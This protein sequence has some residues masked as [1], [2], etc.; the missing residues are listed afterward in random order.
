VAF[1]AGNQTRQTR[2]QSYSVL[3][4][5]DSGFKIEVIAAG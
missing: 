3:K 5:Q 2:R 1:R 4:I